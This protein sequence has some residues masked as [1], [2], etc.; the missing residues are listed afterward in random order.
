MFIVGILSVLRV[1]IEWQW[2][3][4][5]QPLSVSN[6]SRHSRLSSVD[7]LVGEAGIDCRAAVVSG[8]I[9]L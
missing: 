7:V 8:D 4:I 3:Y 5:C 1:N 6:V 2:R 9:I